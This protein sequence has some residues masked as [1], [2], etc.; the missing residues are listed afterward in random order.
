MDIDTSRISNALIGEL[1]AEL[2]YRQLLQHELAE[3]IG[4][5]PAA[6]NRYMKG[7]RDMQMGTYLKICGALGVSPDQIMT[8]AV[9]RAK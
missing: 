5:T 1:R 6:I 8:K 2:A 4:M 7:H 9:E 3:N